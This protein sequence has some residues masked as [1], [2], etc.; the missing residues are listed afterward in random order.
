MPAPTLVRELGTRVLDAEGDLE[1]MQ[2]E[3]LMKLQR[4]LQKPRPAMPMR[5]PRRA[6]CETTPLC[7][8]QTASFL[9]LQQMQRTNLQKQK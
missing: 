4:R 9:E 5:R 1:L 6:N 8:P 3:T 2:A 7:D